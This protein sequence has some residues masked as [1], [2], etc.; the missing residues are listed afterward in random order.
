MKSS[1][2]NPSRSGVGRAVGVP[3]RVPIDEPVVDLDQSNLRL[4]PHRPTV[5]QQSSEPA[6]LPRPPVNWNFSLSPEAR[7]PPIITPTQQLY[8][9]QLQHLARGTGGC[10]SIRGVKLVVPANP[11]RTAPA[12]SSRGVS[13]AARHPPVATLLPS[14]PQGHP[15]PVGQSFDYSSVTPTTTSGQLSLLSSNRRKRHR[16][17]S[18]AMTPV[19]QRAP[20]ISIG[21]G[22]IPEADPQRI[23]QATS[24]LRNVGSNSIHFT[25]PPTKQDPLSPHYGA[26][27][28]TNH[29]NKSNLAVNDTTQEEGAVPEVQQL[30]EGHPELKTHDQRDFL[31]A[32]LLVHRK[33]KNDFDVIKAHHLRSHTNTPVDD[34]AGRSTSSSATSPVT[35]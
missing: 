22:T 14:T 1:R 19:P 25:E 4:S 7:P 10:G 30:F 9:S 23:D 8:S 5:A 2:G 20:P 24:P 32:L 28:I 6:P 3:R 31:L 11:S 29:S 18:T 15:V 27:A 17:S 26:L 35:P 12:G 21:V 33:I 16:D 13:G 34:H